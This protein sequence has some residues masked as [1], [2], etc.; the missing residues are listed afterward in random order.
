MATL[1]PYAG[2]TKRVH[3]PEERATVRRLRQTFAAHAYSLFKMGKGTK[4][5]A[6]EMRI[7]EATALKY[8]T[9][10]RCEAL[11]LPSPYRS[12]LKDAKQPVE[13]EA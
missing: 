7:R 9:L 13:V 1:V 3:I 6:A 2:A 5:I 8:V 10:G 12:F 11:N 4:E